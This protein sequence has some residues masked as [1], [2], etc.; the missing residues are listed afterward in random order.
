MQGEN[1]F[2]LEG[3]AQKNGE[4]EKVGEIAVEN[5]KATVTFDDAASYENY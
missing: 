3:E 1:Q 5:S 2:S 4:N